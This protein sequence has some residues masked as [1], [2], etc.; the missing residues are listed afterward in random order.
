MTTL[1]QL[2][3]ARTAMIVPDAV[4]AIDAARL[5]TRF[6]TIGYRRY[7]LVD[8]GSYDVIENVAAEVPALVVERAAKLVGRP[9]EIEHARVI[10]LIAGDYVFAHHDR[11]H[12]GHP[13][14][15]MLDLSSA[16]VPDAEVHYRRR[17]QV[18]F[19]FGSQP[20]AVSIVERG[21][22]VACNHSYVSKR[23]D[24]ASIVRLI[25][26]LRDRAQAITL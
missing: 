18:F 20:G 22:T 21:P 26:L 3:G 4:A 16:I 15:L 25:V 17:G 13:V 5:R 6:E 2:F 8:R 9:L 10:R 12:E 24:D 14:E 23:H 11:F 1:D 19:R 7:A